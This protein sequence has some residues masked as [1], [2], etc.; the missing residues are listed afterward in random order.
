MRWQCKMECNILTQ[1]SQILRNIVNR[2]QIPKF[3]NDTDSSL[4]VN[5]RQIVPENHYSM[6]NITQPFFVP[7]SILQLSLSQFLWCFLIVTV[8]RSI[9]QITNKLHSAK[10]FQDNQ[11][12]F[13]FELT[14]SKQ[15]CPT[16]KIKL[17][18]P[19]SHYNIFFLKSFNATISAIFAVSNSSLFSLAFVNKRQKLILR[20][21]LFDAIV[22]S[23]EGF[24][25]RSRQQQNSSSVY[26]LKTSP[27]KLSSVSSLILLNGRFVLSGVGSMD[28]FVKSTKQVC[29]PKKSSKSKIPFK[30]PKTQPVC[31]RTISFVSKFVI[32]IIYL[33]CSYLQIEP[34]QENKAHSEGSSQFSNSVNWLV[35][36]LNKNIQFSLVASKLSLYA[37][38]LPKPES[39]QFGMVAICS[40]CQP[41]KRQMLFP[42]TANNPNSV[43]NTDGN[44][45]Y[46]ISS[47]I[48]TPCNG[49]ETIPSQNMVKIQ[50]E[51]IIYLVNLIFRFE[52]QDVGGSKQ[53]T[54]N[55]QQY[56]QNTSAIIFVVDASNLFDSKM[57]ESK[58]CF[59][60]VIENTNEKSK[61]IV[62]GNKQDLPQA[63]NTSEI[64]E[65]LDLSNV[66]NRDVK[67]FETS[68]KNQKGMLAGIQYLYASVTN[69]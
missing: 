20:P 25:M 1:Q 2:V 33:C 31:S 39:V 64:Y 40:T 22:C 29:V 11:F 67:I 18:K 43:G 38:T 57:N 69:Q 17:I 7:S 58:Q 28:L 60:Q 10:I 27:L 59:K 55:W 8:S 61:I 56:Y 6:V 41:H 45:I 14:K 51:I 47:S 68:T 53:N 50:N 15:I 54:F 48:F 66:G 34:A 63:M 44:T 42:Q 36:V 30:Q 32:F 16:S 12:H 52:F 24:A 4:A 65:L 26:T 35:Y 23:N 13:V 5:Q 49:I 46:Q 9:S 37:H 19:T 62:F 21:K 3:P